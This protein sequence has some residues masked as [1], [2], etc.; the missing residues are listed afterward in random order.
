M[1]CALRIGVNALFLIPGG[2]GGTEIYVR[3]LL[4]ALAEIDAM[5]E[6]FVFVNRET[7]ADAEPLA[8]RAPNFREV[9]CAVRAASRPARLL[10]EQ[11]VLPFQTAARRLDVLFSPGFTSPL[12]CAGS[13]VTV[14]HDM[15]HKRR[16]EN[17]G[18]LELAAWRASVWA[19]AH[20]SKRI[21]TVSEESRRDIVEI[22]GVAPE[23]VQ[24]VRHGVEPELFRLERRDGEPPYL[25]S[26]STIHPHKNWGRWMEAFGRLE[27]GRAHV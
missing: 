21:I 2:V 17:F 3:N 27:I 1:P 26:V 16:P 4:S 9:V 13:K 19:S 7:A 18:A 23:R 11:A 5:D 24:V 6:Y 20:F 10:W 12:W 14:I 25:L 8:P 15:Q 22:Y